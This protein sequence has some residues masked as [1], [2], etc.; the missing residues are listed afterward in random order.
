MDNK[1]NVH[2][3]KLYYICDIIIVY[4]ELSLFASVYVCAYVCVRV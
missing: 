3:S 1:I 2:S 4:E